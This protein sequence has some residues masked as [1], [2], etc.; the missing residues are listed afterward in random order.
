[1]EPPKAKILPHDTEIHGDSLNDPYFWLRERDDPEVRAYLAAENEYTNMGLAHTEDLQEKLFVEMRERIKEADYSVPER[2]GGYYYYTRVAEGEEYQ[3]HCRK[4]QSLDAPEEVI[5]DE[6]ELARSAPYFKIGVFELSP[7]QTKLAYSVDTSGSER[8]TIYIKDISTGT[9]YPESFPNTRYAAFAWASDNKTFFY[10]V[11][12]AADR[13]YQVLRHVL[14]TD[15]KGDVLVYHEPDDAY[16]LYLSRTRSQEFILLEIQSQVTGE[17]WYLPARDPAGTFCLIEPRVQGIEYYVDHAGDFFY[18]RT[19]AEA[20]NFRLM[21]TLVHTPGKKYWEEIIPH[22]PAINIERVDVFKHHMVLVER[23]RGLRRI[24][25]I[26]LDTKKECYV[27][28]PEPA[29]M[30][31]LHENPEFDTNVLRFTYESFITPESVYD[32]DMDACAMEA[33]KQ[34]EVLG[35]YNPHAY[36]SERIFVPTL[37]GVEV[38]VSLVYKRGLEKNG[39]H[40][41]YLYGYG[42]YGANN[43]A[44][45]RSYRTSLLDR[46]VIFAVAHVR[47]GGELGR[48]W[49]EGGKL[50]KKKNTFTDFIA[51]SEHLIKMGYTSAERLIAYGASAGGLLMGAVANMRPDLFC[52]IVADVPFVDALNTML[53]PT[54]PLTVM[55]Y[56][57]WGNPVD[58]A[59]YAYIKSYSPYDNI[60]P[61]VYPHMLVIAGF[62]DPRVQY[63]EPAKFVAKLRMCKTDIHR[64]YLKTNMNLG[65]GFSSGRYNFLRDIAFEYAF[66]LDVLGIHD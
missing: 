28:F 17:V 30:C 39:T 44:R 13:P 49:Y 14:A 40:P 21:R 50:L 34:D 29:Y 26:H 65:H 6:N 45:F 15:S 18:I 20:E 10:T 53:D 3:R 63:W 31:W 62:H 51:C 55:E 59:Y 12:D 43:D 61:Q 2:Q 16:S 54:L 4:Y 8:F 7:D 32:Y 38:P 42:A 41:L 33:K 23:E 11:L 48:E 24:R 58:P 22:R 9:I 47:G 46:G 57:E 56:D 66:V 52:A 5:L 35:G 64:L 27:Q 37:D 60:H 36:V 19:N 25:T 1:M